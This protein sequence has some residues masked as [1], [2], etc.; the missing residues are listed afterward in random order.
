MSYGH[1]AAH[2]DT[3]D[4]PVVNDARKAIKAKDVTPVLK[5]V[6]QNDEKAVRAAL[7]KDNRQVC[8]TDLCPD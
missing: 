5:W 8:P 1:A 2:C 3:L 7:G 4:D 6:K